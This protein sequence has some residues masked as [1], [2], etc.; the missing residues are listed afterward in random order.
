MVPKPQLN[1]SKKIYDW[2]EVIQTNPDNEEA[3]EN[4]VI[5]YEKLVHSIAHKYSK[6]QSHHED[7]FQVGM[8]GLLVAVERYDPSFNR[9][10]ETFAIPTIIGEIKRFIRDKTWDVHVPRRIKEL[11]PKINATMTELTEKNQK[12]PQINEIAAHLNVSEEEVLETMEMTS[13]YKSLSADTPQESG[14]DEGNVSI[15]DLIGN[16]EEGYDKI[17]THLLLEK[18]LP[19]LPVREQ[20]ILKCIFFDNMSQQETAEQLDLSQM[21]VSRLQRQALK[22][23]KEALEK[24]GIYRF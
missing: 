24:E 6:N 1:K 16:V 10:F 22:T 3:K 4:V 7:L 13:S 20:Q 15:L 9:T 12:T 17:D 19:I 23:L 18:I 8:I 2:I 14:T 21:H 5:H 11:G